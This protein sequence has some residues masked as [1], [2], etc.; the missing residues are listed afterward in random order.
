LASHNVEGDFRVGPRHISANRRGLEKVRRDL[1]QVLRLMDLASLYDKRIDDATWQAIREAMT[2]RVDVELTGEV[3]RRFLSLLAQPARLGDLLRRLHELHVLEKIV[4]GLEHARNLVQ[5]NDYHKYTVDE[6]CLRAVEEATKF[7]D[8]PSPVGDVYRS[9]KNKRLLHLALLL[10]DLGKGYPEDHSEVGARLA[11]QAAARLRLPAG[12]AEILRFLIHKH[13][14]FSDLAQLR[15]VNDSDV[16]VGLAVE[17]GSPEVLQLLYV[18]TCADLAAVGPGV[19]NQWKLEILTRLYRNALRELTGDSVAGSRVEDHAR[20]RKELLNR[21]PGTGERAWWERQIAALPPAYLYDGPAERILEDLQ[22]FS[23]LGHKDAVAYGRYLSDFR[24]VEYTVGT[25]DEIVPGIFHRLTGVLTSQRHEI[26]SAEINTLADGLVLDRFHV[27]DRDFEGPPPADRL[28]DISRRLV[29]ALKSPTSEP[30]RF[31]SLWGGEPK[32]SAAGVL[33]PPVQ[34][35]I[36]NSTSDRFTILDIFAVDRMGLL[37]TITRLLFEG[38]LSVHMAKIG[39]HLDQVVD[40][41]YVTDLAGQKVEDED[42]LQAIRSTLT[43]QIAEFEE[44]GLAGPPGNT[45]R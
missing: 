17:V 20:C 40:V 23:R 2:Q 26:L 13:L 21:F 45:P 28:E 36:D 3:I 43:Q 22:R 34:V 14:L 38:G 4:P 42:R 18:M 5:F 15:D 37:Y 7:L 19:L 24:A 33:R 9:L 6:H 16:V 11:D 32:R 12:D 31:P 8:D 35:R 30:P 10:H 1:A 39:S 41:F 25:Y 44:H 29:A 27:Q